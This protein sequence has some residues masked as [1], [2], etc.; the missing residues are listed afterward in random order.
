MS[1]PS[2]RIGF[3]AVA[4]LG[5]FVATGAA[6]GVSSAAEQQSGLTPPI[7]T[8]MAYAGPVN[9]AWENSSGWLLCDGRRLD[10]SNPRYSRLFNAI[11][12]SWGGDGAPNFY[13]PDLR[14]R[15]LRGVDK[16]IQGVETGSEEGGPRDP[17]RNARTV[18]NP[19]NTSPGAQGNSG[20]NVG[21]LQSDEFARHTHDISPQLNVGWSVNGNGDARRFDTDDG[22]SW[23]GT[24]EDMFAMAAGG[25]ETRPRNAN[26]YWIIRYR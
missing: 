20:N 7:G 24:N 10:R 14:G 23:A 13:L 6:R 26:V 2:R 19:Y 25:N 5:A 15:F 16:N 12:T 3:L 21:S 4:L 22:P 9:A 8:I 17:D 11:G 1:Q 18:S